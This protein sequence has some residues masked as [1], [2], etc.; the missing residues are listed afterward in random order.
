MGN[1]S[2]AR[3]ELNWKPKFNIKSLIKDMINYE[4]FNDK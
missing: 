3:K 1:S 4:F 2:K